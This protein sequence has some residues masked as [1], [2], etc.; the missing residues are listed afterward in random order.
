MK[1]TEKELT[2]LKAI[3]DN[4]L[5]GMG[6]QSYTD[7]Q[8]DNYSWF[9]PIDLIKLTKYTKHQIAGLMSTLHEKGLI[10]ESDGDWCLTDDGIEC[11]IHSEQ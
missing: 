4:G 1:L 9:Q 11:L 5:S 6:G 8:Y 3:G 2:T 7:L 10:I